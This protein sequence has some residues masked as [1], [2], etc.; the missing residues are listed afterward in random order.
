MGRAWNYIAGIGY[1]SI[2]GFSFVIT[3][4]ALEALDPFELVFLRFS[5]AALVMSLLAATGAI[6]LD[7]RGKRRGHLALA[8]AFQPVLY[9]TCETF[10]VRESAASM[11]GIVLGTLPAVVAVLGAF[12]LRERV[13]APQA[14]CLGLSVL[15]VAVVVALGGAIGG[16]SGT[17]AGLLFL[18]GAVASAAL[19]NVYSRKSSIA[20]SPAETTF[21]M[22]W[23]GAVVFGMVAL[24]RGAILGRLH[25]AEGLFSRALPTWPSLLY[26]GALSSV[27]GFFLVN[28]TLARLRASQ[29][30]VFSNLTTVVAVGAGVLVRGEP[31]GAAQLAGSAMIVLGVWGTNAFAST[32]RG[33]SAPPA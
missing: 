6:K 33:N 17:P 27:L 8:C 20:F 25:G 3:K 5:I 12:M 21:A 14:A 13:G 28:F 18:L 1:A 11:A 32:P 4:D 9:F 30:A 19:Y 10:G 26:L 15:G 7:F 2:F 16:E 24:G 31:L 22:M 23:T 29:S